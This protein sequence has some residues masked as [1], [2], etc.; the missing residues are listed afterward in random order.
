[1]PRPWAVLSRLFEKAGAFKKAER[2]VESASREPCTTYTRRLVLPLTKLKARKFEL[3]RE[4]LVEV[5]LIA[6][7]PLNFEAPLS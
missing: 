5:V 1:M 3:T 4:C 2:I 6:Y 7:V